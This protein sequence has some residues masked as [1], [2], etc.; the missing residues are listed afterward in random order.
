MKQLIT[1]ISIMSVVLCFSSYSTKRKTDNLLLKKDSYGID[2]SRHQGRIKWS[3][4]AKDTNIVFVYIKATEGATYTDPQYLYNLTQARKQGL[5]VGVYHYFRTTSSV[6]EQFKHFKKTC[7][8]DSLDLIPMID[9]ENCGNWSRE[10]VQKAVRELCKLVEKE[11]GKKPMIYSV[12]NTYNKYLA[13]EF[14]D[15]PLYLGRYGNNAPVIRGKGHYTIWQYSE[16]SMVNGIP[17]QVD[18]CRF[19]Q[20]KSIKDITLQ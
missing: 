5:K 16:R 7:P 20:N 4:V 10:Q 14:N 18:N 15:F 9:V 2:V 12:Q 13:P 1:I 11:Y 17:K 8:K 19:H 3:A 6:K